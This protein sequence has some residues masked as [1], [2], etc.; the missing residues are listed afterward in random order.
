MIGRTATEA[1]LRRAQRRAGLQ[2]PELAA[3]APASG[4]APAKWWTDGRHGMSYLR[5]VVR[6]LWPLLIEITGPVVVA[7][8]ERRGLV[9]N[10]EPPRGEGT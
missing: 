3:L 10:G 4:G 7:R 8:L 5:A 6:E 9:P 2:H 1:L